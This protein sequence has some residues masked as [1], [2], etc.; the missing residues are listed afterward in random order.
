MKTALKSRSWPAYLTNLL[1]FLLVLAGCYTVPET[2]RTSINFI[3]THHELSMGISEF[4]KIKKESPI[5]LDPTLVGRLQ[6]VGWRIS[7]A[8]GNDLPSADWEF[9]LFDEPDIVNAFALPG[10]KVGIYS[11]IMEIAQTDDEL[12]T[13]VAHEI[14]HVTARHGSERT[15]HGV[16]AAVFGNILNEALEGDDD[17]EKYL[18]AYG[19]GTTFAVTLPFSRS[20]ELEADEI[21]LFYAAKAGYDPRAA[22]EFWMKMNLVK[23][24]DKSNVFFSTH[25]SDYQRIDKLEALMPQAV[26]IYEQN[27]SRQE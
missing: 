15:S 9:V 1:G 27:R 25:P 8:V 16:L 5:S 24:K 6:R 2:G 7:Q 20:H 21:G 12:A 10:G 14:A 18:A 19:L 11:G 22:V 26:P 13:V 17:R 4:E 23:D 3:G